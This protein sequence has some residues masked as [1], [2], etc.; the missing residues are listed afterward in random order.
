VKAQEQAEVQ[1]VCRWYHAQ[2]VPV[3][4]GCVSSVSN[5]VKKV[6]SLA[7]AVG[8]LLDWKKLDDPLMKLRVVMVASLARKREALWVEGVDCVICHLHE[9]L[10]TTAD[11][12]LRRNAEGEIKRALSLSV[13]KHCVLRERMV[14]V[15]DRMSW[16][17]G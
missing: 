13:K 16:R 5:P 9:A 2:A 17:K 15:D 1:P 12:I 6:R 7:A 8:G 14:D 11:W 10:N 3:A 4:V